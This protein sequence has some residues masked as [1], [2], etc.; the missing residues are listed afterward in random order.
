MSKRKD[1]A[2]LTDIQICIN[3]IKTF[4]EGMTA[5]DFDDDDKTQD[6][7]IRNLEVI[8]EATKSLSEDILGT[9]ADIPWHAIARTRDKLIHHYFGVNLDTVWQIVRNEIPRLSETV[10][11]A[12]KAYE[13]SGEEN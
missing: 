4:T 6:A 9:Y 2:L 11:Q 7:V 8:G 3:K 1:Q 13:D 12:L 5:T 10:D